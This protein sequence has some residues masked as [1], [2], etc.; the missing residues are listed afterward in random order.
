MKGRTTTILFLF[1]LLEQTFTSIS[2]TKAESASGSLPIPVL[3]P[4]NH[5]Y[6]KQNGEIEPPNLPIN[7]TGNIY[8]LT[9]NIENY[10]IEV[11]CDNI[12]IDG[13]GFSLRGENFWGYSGLTLSNVDNVV[14][15]N[16][17]INTFM[18]GLSLSNTNHITVNSNLINCQEDIDFHTCK[19]SQISENTFSGGGLYGQQINNCLISENYF[20]PPIAA[21]DFSASNYNN[22]T[23]NYVRT[24][25]VLGEYSPCCF[26]ILS[27]NIF[28]G[29]G[30]GI[31][32]MGGSSNNSV[33]HNAIQ[34]ENTNIVLMNAQNNLICENSLM[35]GKYGI[36]IDNSMIFDKNLPSSD[37]NTFFLNNFLNCTKPVVMK[38][39]CINFW[40]NGSIGNYWSDYLVKYPAA[41]EIDG[42][43]IGDTPYVLDENNSDLYPLMKPLNVFNDTASVPPKIVILSPSTLTYNESSLPLIFAIDKTVNWMSY[44]IDGSLNVTVL[45]NETITKISNGIHNITVYTNDTFGNID[46]S[47][48]INFSVDVISLSKQEPLSIATEVAVA[49]TIAI[50]VVAISLLLYRRHRKTISQNKPNV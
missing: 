44:S 35:N 23:K 22:I 21:I 18:Y 6:I 19:D 46:T 49:S 40:D 38:Q 4:I 8:T 27:E 28:N 42:N 1:L 39:G 45:G 13:S 29:L 16:F 41:S 43:G 47:D 25:I 3:L 32:L 26:N 30:I 14:I 34:T 11:Q 2:L 31:R 17:K 50:A 37:N 48:I 33:I 10:T 5:G 12:T 20:S 9:N 7:K 36:G 15:R 24:I